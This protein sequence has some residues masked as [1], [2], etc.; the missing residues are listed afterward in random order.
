MRRRAGAR[1]PWLGV[2][3][4]GGQYAT[5]GDFFSDFGQAGGASGVVL[6][7]VVI[8]WGL[9]GK[10]LG[11]GRMAR[12]RDGFKNRLQSRQTGGREANR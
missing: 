6:C 2:G 9:A 3:V 1:P 4:G 8:F 5:G 10:G 7:L 12:Q 11:M